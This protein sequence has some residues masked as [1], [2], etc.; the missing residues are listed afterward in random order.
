MLLF[1]QS[2]ADSPGTGGGRPHRSGQPTKRRR[3]GQHCRRTGTGSGQKSFGT[4]RAPGP[5][6]HS[7][8]DYDPPPRD[9]SRSTHPLRPSGGR[10]KT[11]PSMSRIRRSC[12]NQT[13]APSASAG[14][15]AANAFRA[16]RGNAGATITRSKDSKSPSRC[17]CRGPSALHRGRRNGRRR[18]RRTKPHRELD[19]SSRFRLASSSASRLYFFARLTHLVLWI[20]IRVRSVFDP[21]LEILFASSLKATN[22]R[23]WP[24]QQARNS[25]PLRLAKFVQ[26][27]TTATAPRV[28]PY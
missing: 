13:H 23:S 26:T 24:K 21:W 2:T 27:W 1:H 25:V 18:R 16:P 14:H 5:C 11:G 22:A 15:D 17:R 10:F 19:C 4:N 8:S 12:C 9:F 3:S 6:K 7:S 20:L 28:T